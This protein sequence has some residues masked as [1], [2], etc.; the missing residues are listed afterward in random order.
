[1]RPHV[2]LRLPDGS[3]GIAAAGDLIGRLHSAAV[4][5]DD[6]RVSE[7]HALVSLRGDQLVLLALRG[8]FAV[9][10]Q[11]LERLVLTSGL[12]IH[13]ARDL[14]IAVEEVV[15]PAGVLGLRGPDLPTQVLPAVA[16]LSLSPEPRLTP[17]YTSKASAT[18]WTTG[19]GWRVRVGD[20]PARPL[21]SGDS[22]EVDRQTFE[23]VRLDLQAAAQDAT[24][25]E[26]GLYEPLWVEAMFD[27][28]RIHRGD[29]VAVTL[30][31]LPARI[32]AEL[33]EMG[34]PCG[35]EPLSEV[36]WSDDPHRHSRR[37]KFD[38]VLA[39]LRRKLREAEVRQDLVQPDGCG[40]V[41]LLLY[42][43][44]RCTVGT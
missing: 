29:T 23:V 1:M 39:R 4:H 14:V 18:F 12:R 30:S 32:V 42:A 38:L 5:V 15:L 25:R 6:A 24:R 13:L 26:G 2:T 41:Q 9:D 10:G 36:L 34:V 3:L 21:S 35:W 11:P 17:R 19:D 40:N 31:G 22:V 33:A 37:R 20:G 27:V 16:S 43:D 44:D 28:V 7:A 8:R